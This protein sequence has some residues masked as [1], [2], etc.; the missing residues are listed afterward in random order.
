MGKLTDNTLSEGP[1]VTFTNTS[2]IDQIQDNLL[3]SEFSVR[4]QLKGF[5]VWREK[6][7]IFILI[8]KLFFWSLRR[9]AVVNESD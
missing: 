5:Y 6:S 1:S 4:S 7:E 8:L 9:G 3:L 2:P